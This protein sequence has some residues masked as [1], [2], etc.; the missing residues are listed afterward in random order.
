M[1]VMVTGQ[2][3]RFVT[4]DFPAASRAAIKMAPLPGPSSKRQNGRCQDRRCEGPF[5]L[6]E[7]HIVKWAQLKRVKVI[8]CRLRPLL[9]QRVKHLPNQKFPIWELSSGF[10][11]SG[12]ATTV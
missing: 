11:L 1:A 10:A 9:L 2:F 3:T 7:R 8:A 4:C 12:E 5:R 6:P